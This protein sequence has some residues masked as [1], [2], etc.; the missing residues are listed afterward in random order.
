MVKPRLDLI[1]R[2][3]DCRELPRPCKKKEPEN[4]LPPSFGTVLT[5]MPLLWI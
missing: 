3:S 1:D 2:L 5:R 4:V